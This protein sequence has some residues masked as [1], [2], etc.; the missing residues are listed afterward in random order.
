MKSTA[1]E[2]LSD[3][4]A[5]GILIWAFPPDR[6]D[7]AIRASGRAG[8]RTRL[9]PPLITVYYV[10][11]MC[12][13]PYKPYEELARLLAEGLAL[14]DPTGVLSLSC[15]PSTAAISRARMRLGIQPL[16]ELFAQTAVRPPVEGAPRF[17]R[18][19]LWTLTG[20]TVNLPDHA[21]QGGAP[22]TPRMRIAVVA[23]HGTGM[24]IGAQVEPLSGDP[25]KSADELFRLL[26]PGDLLVA[27]A[28]FAG[29]ELAGAA[30][31][32]G[33]DLLW[34]VPQSTGLP[35]TETLDDG[36]YLSVP[37]SWPDDPV[38]GRPVVRVVTGAKCAER[39]VTTLLDPAQATR[40]ELR[41]VYEAR[42][43]FEEAAEQL[44]AFR[45]TP[46]KAMRSRSP[47]MMEQELWGYLLVYCAIRNLA[48]NR[49]L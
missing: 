7:G 18:S 5:I 12:L 25:S 47:E 9:L 38:R 17:R 13:F 43:R 20:G 22:G 6:V 41:G 40:A 4:L 35:V 30:L 29:P 36:S 32:T 15:V 26:G 11:A 1:E 23:E 21:A 8:I 49:N 2:R 10:L 39:L 28:E 24:L 33:A 48:K 44:D 27:Q 46:K 31:A 42:W 45:R 16:R 37:A 3:R 14:S 34:S 19:R